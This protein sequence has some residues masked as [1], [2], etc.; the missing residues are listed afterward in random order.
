MLKK[1]KNFFLHEH[2]GSDELHKFYLLILLRSKLICPWGT[3]GVVAID[4]AADSFY[5]A[6]ACP[7]KTVVD[8]L[9]A[10]DTFVASTIHALIQGKSLQ[11]S[12]DFGC[13]I[14]G[15]KVGFYG[16]DEISEVFVATL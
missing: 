7:P 2:N 14:A 1:S 8:S 15:A 6:T 9:G 12:I 4:N 10:G 13:Q 16:Y 5:T 3:D 11:E